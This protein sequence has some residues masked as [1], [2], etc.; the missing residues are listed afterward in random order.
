MQYSFRLRAGGGVARGGCETDGRVPMGKA[1]CVVE[2]CTRTLRSKLSLW[3][4]VAFVLRGPKAFPDGD[5]S[6]GGVVAAAVDIGLGAA[7]VVRARRRPR[8]WEVGHGLGIPDEE[9]VLH[10]ASREARH[11][12]LH[13]YL[14]AMVRVREEVHPKCPW[15]FCSYRERGVIQT[16]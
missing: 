7:G 10:I 12:V 1:T 16:L 14:V 5:A 13:K 3:S 8:E 2:C 15:T 11:Q 6:A 4:C 9:R